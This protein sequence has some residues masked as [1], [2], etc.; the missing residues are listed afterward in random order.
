M[1][2][3]SKVQYDEEGTL[4]KDEFVTE[5]DRKF[6]LNYPEKDRVSELV[7]KFGKG[8]ITASCFHYEKPVNGY[9]G[10]VWPSDLVSRYLN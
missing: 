5:D 4:K 10:Y 3:V 7:K 9:H 6:V 8:T 2:I 1:S